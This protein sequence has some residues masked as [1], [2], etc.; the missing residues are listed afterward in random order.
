ERGRPDGRQAHDRADRQVDAARGDDE[1]HADADHAGDGREAEDRDEVAGA[2][3]PLAGRRDADEHEQ[4]EGEHEAAHPQGRTH[5]GRT[6]AHATLPSMTR[7]STRCSSMSRA[8]PSWTA[9]PAE[10][11]RTLSASPSTSGISLDT[12]TT[13]APSS[14]R[15]R[16]RV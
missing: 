6:L 7:S 1:C 16:I 11:T 8:G 2:P 4:D 14:A 12:T 9:L 15:R 10:M 13:A 3:E 5:E